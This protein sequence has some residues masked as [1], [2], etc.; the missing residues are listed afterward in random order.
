MFYGSFAKL[1]GTPPVRCNGISFLRFTLI[2]RFEGYII[3]PIFLSF[4]LF[5]NLITVLFKGAIEY[6]HP[7]STC[8]TI[9]NMVNLEAT[10]INMSPLIEVWYCMLD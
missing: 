2:Y 4:F 9:N 6:G 7:D 8:Y 3:E 1:S 10:K 5:L